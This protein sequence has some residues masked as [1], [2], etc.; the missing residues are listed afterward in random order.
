MSGPCVEK[1][2]ERGGGD[3][4]VVEMGGVVCVWNAL[5]S[6]EL[7]HRALGVL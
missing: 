4:A 7:R 5:L 1:G 2:Q 6:L 3:F